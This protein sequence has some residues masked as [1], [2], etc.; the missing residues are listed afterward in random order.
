VLPAALLV[1]SVVLVFAD[2]V[3]HT[4]GLAAEEAGITPATR[5]V[6]LLHA[7]LVPTA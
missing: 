6:Y 2:E 4:S 5:G 1:R 3:E 7:Q